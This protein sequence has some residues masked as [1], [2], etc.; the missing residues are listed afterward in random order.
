MKIFFR[1]IIPVL[2]V[3]IL[4]GMVFFGHQGTTRHIKNLLSEFSKKKFNTELYI[5]YINI[6]P[7]LYFELNNVKIGDIANIRSIRI[8]PNLTAFLVNRKDIGVKVSVI[9]PKIVVKKENTKQVTISDF[10]ESKKEEFLTDYSF[11]TCY[12]SSISVQK[13][14]FIYD[15]DTSD[16]ITL[17]NIRGN[18][19]GP[20]FH[21]GRPNVFNFNF[22]G[23]LK[24][25]DSNL[26]SPLRLAGV[27]KSTK[28]IK[29]E[30]FASDIDVGIFPFYAK[31]INQMIK[32]ATLDFRSDIQIVENDLVADCF[33]KAKDIILKEGTQI[34]AEPPF[35]AT[36]LL[37]SNLKNKAFK[38]KELQGNLLS[39]A[40]Q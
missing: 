14:T 5:G 1:K 8:Q 28:D 24:N 3:L 2:L 4:S 22:L 20:K 17:V 37:F 30:F 25:K 16:P 18:L 12:F 23:F 19:R 39:L 10:I 34:S 33:I 31:Y 29:A 40:L 27:A 26:T 15:D 11:L 6:R 13:G 9:E 7:P 38:I 35:I 36:F 21:F 32:G